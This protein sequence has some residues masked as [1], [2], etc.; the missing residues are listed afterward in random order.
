MRYWW[1]DLEEAP[2]E[3]DLR[4]LAEEIIPTAREALDHGTTSNQ[5]LAIELLRKLGL[6]ARP[7]LDH[8]DR[9]RESDKYDDEVRSRAA[10][11]IREIDPTYPDES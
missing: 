8:L 11:A 1:D 5:L 4:P 3:S 7:M 10:T 9:V 2:L 6:D